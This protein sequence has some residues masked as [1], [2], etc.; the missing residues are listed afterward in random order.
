[1]SAPVMATVEP[2]SCMVV[3]ELY[4]VNMVLFYRKLLL[5]RSTSRMTGVSALPFQLLEWAGRV[6]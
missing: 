2:Q 5:L 1:M 4:N 3:R 6:S